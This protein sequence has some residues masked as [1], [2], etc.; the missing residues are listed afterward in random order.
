VLDKNP[1][2]MALD[3]DIGN[4]IQVNSLNLILSSEALVKT[5]FLAK[6]ID[7][8]KI[9]VIY[10]DLDFLYTGYVTSGIIAQNENVE[11]YRPNKENFEASLK[12][13]VVQI[14]NRK[15]IVIID[16]LNG[17]F[18]LYDEKD[19]GRQ[20]NAFIMFLLCIARYSDSKIIVASVGKHVEGEGWIL[21]PSGRHPIEIEDMTRIYLSRQENGIL[22]QVLNK[23]N[24]PTRSALI[25][26]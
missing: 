16:S 19:S 15:S 9:P 24:V 25:S 23:K 13:I 14:S 8:I 3:D 7:R 4:V 2:T 12:D 6:I 5:G 20:V 10:M 21:T 17:I 11:V 26:F 18:T 22:S 1:D